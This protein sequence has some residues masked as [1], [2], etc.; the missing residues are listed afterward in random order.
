L[1]SQPRSIVAPEDV[2]LYPDRLRRL[3][4]CISR[5]VDEDRIP[6]AVVLIARYGQVAFFE[7]FGFSDP[8]TRTPMSR[9]SLFR[10]ASLTK[11]MTCAAAVMLVE[12]GE[13]FLDDPLSK[14]IPEFEGLRAQAGGPQKQ[15]IREATLHDLFRHTAGF[16]YGEFGTSAVH[17]SYRQLQVLDN[18]QTSREMAEKLS[19]IP[20]AYQPGTTFEYGMSTDVLGHIVERVTAQSLEDVL[21]SLIL[22]PLGLSDT[23]FILDRRHHGRLAQASRD[24]ATAVRP[25]MPVY[26]DSYDPPSWHSGGAGLLSTAH[27]YFAFLQMLLDGGTSHELRL[28]ASKSVDWMVSN[29]L[30]P[31]V[32]YGEYMETLGMMSPTPERGQGFGLGFLVRLELGRNSVPGSIG[33]FSWAGVSGTYAWADPVERLVVVL[34]MQAPSERTRYRALMRQLVYQALLKGS[35][36]RSKEESK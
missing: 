1:R 27:D 31:N 33:D 3:S 24:A 21:K 9:D 6:G 30:P 29:H 20:L 15:R 35:A 26:H 17:Q 34:M 12:K 22:R 5:D 13:L 19:K 28:L 2:G 23:T 11:P 7:A 36:N 14:H 32:G 8:D 16:T 18:A 10:L 4:D 25:W